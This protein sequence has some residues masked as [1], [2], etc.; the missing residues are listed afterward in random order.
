MKML[1]VS[2]TALCATWCLNHKCFYTGHHK[3]ALSKISSLC[4]DFI[5]HWAFPFPRHS[6]AICLVHCSTAAGLSVKTKQFD[7]TWCGWVLLLHCMHMY[8]A[9]A[10]GCGCSWTFKILSAGSVSIDTCMIFWTWSGYEARS[11]K[12]EGRLMADE[13]W[14]IAVGGGSGVRG[15]GLRPDRICV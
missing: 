11:S 15:A 10:L 12:D 7:I 5:F 3:Q 4:K 8:C 14:A 1:C 9:I 6:F 13:A 2:A